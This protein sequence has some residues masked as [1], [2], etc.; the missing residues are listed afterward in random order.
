MLFLALV[1]VESRLLKDYHWFLGFFQGYYQGLCSGFTVEKTL[2]C[3]G[4]LD[5]EFKAE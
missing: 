4:G 3:K 2:L 5:I 1:N